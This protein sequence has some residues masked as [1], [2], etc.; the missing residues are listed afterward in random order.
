MTLSGKGNR[1]GRVS[2]PFSPGVVSI[3]KHRITLIDIPDLPLLPRS[4]SPPASLCPHR[5]A[6]VADIAIV[7]SISEPHPPSQGS[8][9][10][11]HQH[12]RSTAQLGKK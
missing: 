10:A 2:G 4:S 5:T 12:P 3:F 6:S 8:T 9:P 11:H 7:L 1:A